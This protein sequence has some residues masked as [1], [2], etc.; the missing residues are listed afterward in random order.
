MAAQSHRRLSVPRVL[1]ILFLAGLIP[2]VAVQD[3]SARRDTVT[4][5]V[6]IFSQ[7]GGSGTVSG[8]LLNG[9]LVIQCPGDCT[10]TVN[11]NTTIVLTLH[12]TS[13]STGDWLNACEGVPPPTCTYNGSASA[14][15]TGHFVGVTQPLSV[16]LTG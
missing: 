3:A 5:T 7:S 6:S 15:A 8:E 10:E 13:G 2:A 11:R 4:L 16:D 14:T 9:D 12:P 1:L